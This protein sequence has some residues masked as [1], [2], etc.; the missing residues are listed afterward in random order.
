MT[1][2]WHR[3][4]SMARAPR[5]HRLVDGILVS[6]SPWAG[7]VFVQGQVTID[8][9][10]G[11]FDDLLGVGWRLVAAPDVA[12]AIPI[13]LATW[14]SSIGGRIVTIDPSRDV[15]DVDGTYAEWF[16]DRGMKAALQRPDFYFFGTTSNADGVAALISELQQRLTGS[17][18]GRAGEE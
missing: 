9:V 10:T 6:G 11:L 15:H 3:W 17:T 2:R 13:D 5:C 1:R 14:F 18:S 8:G 4:S 7:D 16:A 12:I